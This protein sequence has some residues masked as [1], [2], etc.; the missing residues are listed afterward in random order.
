[1][2]APFHKKIVDGTLRLLVQ[3]A[4]Q[5]TALPLALLFGPRPLELHIVDHANAKR[6]YGDQ[7]EAAS[8]DHVLLLG[9]LVMQIEGGPALDGRRH[10]YSK[11]IRL[12]LQTKMVVLRTGR[13]RI[14]E[15]A[16]A[17]AVPVPQRNADARRIRGQ[18]RNRREHL[19]I[20]G[21]VR[22]GQILEAMLRQRVRLDA[23]AD[24]GAIAVGQWDFKITKNFEQRAYNYGVVGRGQRYVVAEVDQFVRDREHRPAAQYQSRLTLDVRKV[25]FAVGGRY[26][27]ELSAQHGAAVER[28]RD[29]PAIALHVQSCKFDDQAL[30]AEIRARVLHIREDN[31]AV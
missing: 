13:V 12:S 5:V 1:M 15:H 14:A 4:G 21:H 20:V 23:H 9:S 29:V 7:A 3:D 10:A 8:A 30:L 19:P 18:R 26:L 11:H 27:F 17:V 25:V 2:Y 31:G 16:R 24:V 6:I 22:R 28:E